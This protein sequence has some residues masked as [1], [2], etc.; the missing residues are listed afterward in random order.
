MTTQRAALAT[1]FLLALAATA[2][3]LCVSPDTTAPTIQ[4]YSASAI[5]DPGVCSATVF[6]R[7]PDTFDACGVDL[8]SS[9]NAVSGDTYAP[10]TYTTVY[11]ATDPSSNFDS[12]T[13]SVT[14]T[15]VEAPTVTGCPGDIVLSV[16]SGCTA[17]ATWDDS[18]VASTDNCGVTST[19]QSHVSGATF[20]SGVT[21]VSYS[22]VD[23]ANN[24]GSCS[25]TVT[26]E[27]TGSV[28]YSNCPSDIT[29]DSACS[30]SGTS[31]TWSE[32]SLA[33]TCLS[34]SSRNFAPGERFPDGVTTISYVAVEDQRSD[35]C[36]FDI[37][38]NHC[39]AEN[40]ANRPPG[41]VGSIDLDG[42]GYYSD[43]PLLEWRDCC[44]SPEDPCDDP[45]LVNPGAFEIPHNDQQDSC[46]GTS[47]LQDSDSHAD[48]CDREFISGNDFDMVGPTI[49]SSETHK[50]AYAFD[51]CEFQEDDD[52][53]SWGLDEQQTLIFSLANGTRNGYDIGIFGPQSSQA[54]VVNHYGGIV[55]VR[56]VYML[57]ISSGTARDE[58]T[59][60]HG[61]PSGAQTGNT[62][63]NLPA[64]FLD[65]GI[66]GFIEDCSTVP[67]A[68]G[69]DS[70]RAYFGMR[71]PTNMN[72][73]SFQALYLDNELQDLQGS[74]PARGTCVP[75]RQSWF[76][77]IKT[78]SKTGVSPSGNF[79]GDNTGRSFNSFNANAAFW[80]QCNDYG[81]AASG[82]CRDG[83]TDLELTGYEGG[84]N[85]TP[86]GTSAEPGEKFDIEFVTFDGAD[87]DNDVTVLIDDYYPITEARTAGST[88]WASNPW[89]YQFQADLQMV[90]WASSSGPLISSTTATTV[91]LDFTLRNWG[92]EEANDVTVS[93]T[94]PL[95][96]KFTSAKDS[97]GAALSCT[98]F[99]ALA[100]YEDN[101]FVKCKWPSNQPL[102][103]QGTRSGVIAF[104]LDLHC[105]ACPLHT[106]QL[107]FRLTGTHS[108]IDRE[109]GNNYL[110]ANIIVL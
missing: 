1:I 24:V 51:L 105:D 97:T 87:T 85:W 103:N 56:G 7:E 78:N 45:Y 64:T 41:A 22:A 71:Q 69:L 49:P 25:F 35:T 67:Y 37:I 27:L 81:D 19:F 108:S 75:N 43:A 95:G 89:G 30:D 107:R 31:V 57:A 40:G 90:H 52:D 101:G 55:P 5:T 21:L 100:P 44:D 54:S 92:P 83:S 8:T 12:C 4:C 99:P 33:S 32:P 29:V 53:P 86:I 62:A 39:P 3:A 63:V 76:L 47:V 42:D 6:F 50:A 84:S 28:L 65:G 72:G 13:T 38:V 79:A 15:D 16:A 77:A 66:S 74:Y 94:P 2:N 70:I 9:G 60:G 82:L 91:N 58:T 68:I 96:T 46:R 48:G 59:G 20:G 14:V 26:V 10:G 110:T 93:F 17:T 34:Y 11:T 61:S 23:A 98:M 88:A 73:F 80:S 109:L 102:A 104:A 106:N 36:I 18:L